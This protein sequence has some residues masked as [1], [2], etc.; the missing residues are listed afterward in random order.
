MK[1]LYFMLVLLLSGCVTIEQDNEFNVPP[2]LFS[3]NSQANILIVI[4]VESNANW[5]EININT[6]NSLI[7]CVVKYPSKGSIIPGDTIHIISDGDITECKLEISYNQKELGAW[8]FQPKRE[9]TYIQSVEQNKT[10][11]ESDTIQ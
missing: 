10:A 6:Q 8:I 1:F 7:P 11:T 2:I 5:D 3:A 9:V 4:G